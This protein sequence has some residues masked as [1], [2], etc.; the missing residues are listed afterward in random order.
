VEVAP[1]VVREHDR[2]AVDQRPIHIETANRLGDRRKPVGEV[3]AAAAP[4]LDA[5]ALLAGEDA[6]TV[7]LDLV[8]PAR[9]GGRAIGERGLAR[10]NE[11]DLADFVASGAL[12]RARLRS[13]RRHVTPGL[14]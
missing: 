14:R 1:S 6:E 4:D 10:V 9:S 13:W 8:Q 3:R 11:A 5:L 7:M 2:L 12:G